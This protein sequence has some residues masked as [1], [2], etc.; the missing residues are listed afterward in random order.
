MRTATRA[1]GVT[2]SGYFTWRARRPSARSIRHT[3]LTELIT[4]IHAD[5]GATH[6]Y[7]RIHR[8]LTQ[9]YEIA[10]SHGTVELLIRRAGIHGRPGDGT[11]S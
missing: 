5:S 2:E 8:E 4:T 7:R 10:V 9:T 3:W 1:L 11:P 6:G